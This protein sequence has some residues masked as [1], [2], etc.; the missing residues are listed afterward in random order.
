MSPFGK[1]RIVSEGRDATIL[2]WGALVQKS[3]D[4]A[5]ELEREGYS[6]E[7]IDARTLVPFDMETL[8]SSLEKTNKVL[9]CHEETKTSGFAGEIAA[10]INEECF[11][12]L[13]AP[14]LRVTAKDS[15]VPYCPQL[16][17]DILPQVTD[18]VSKLR[19][20]LKY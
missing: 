2:A 10:R 14:I 3:I 6:I 4:A 12:S 20:L 1:A 9:I 7:I 17:D 18:V 5:K 13:D 8:K 16:E 15:H 19:E 11:E